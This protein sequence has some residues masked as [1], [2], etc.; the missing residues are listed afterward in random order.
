VV[1]YF[2]ARFSTV[3]IAGMATP[4]KSVTNEQVALPEMQ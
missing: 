4:A 3:L 2:L 1:R